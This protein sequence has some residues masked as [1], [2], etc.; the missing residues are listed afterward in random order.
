MEDALDVSKC[1][2]VRELS[3]AERYLQ[4]LV[5]QDNELHHAERVEAE[6]LAQ[7]KRVAAHLQPGLQPAFD[8]A[9]NHA[10][11]DHG[12][13]RRVTRPQKVTC[14]CISR[15]RAKLERR[16][17]PRLVE[18]PGHVRGIHVEAG[19]NGANMPRYLTV[20]DRINPTIW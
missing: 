10:R 19:W 12:K 9:L 4:H 7:T 18:V 3:V 6:I 15:G 5:S 8:I 14:R 13:A 2:Q 11:D 20:I 17:Q 16:A 1:T